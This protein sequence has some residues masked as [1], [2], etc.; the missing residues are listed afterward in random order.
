M[1][2]QS[3]LQEDE[4]DLLKFYPRNAYE[5]GQDSRHDDDEWRNWRVDAPELDTVDEWVST[6]DL[7]HQTVNQTAEE[8]LGSG[9]HD[10]TH[11]ATEL[12][13]GFAKAEGLRC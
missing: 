3:D 13:L 4:D 11:I 1:G 12:T 6:M 9:S 10:R 2:G 8:R 7:L 5:D